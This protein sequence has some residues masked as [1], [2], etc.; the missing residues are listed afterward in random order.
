MDTIGLGLAGFGTV[1]SGVYR[2]LESN[3][4]LFAQRLGCIPLVKRIAVR[5]RTKWRPDNPPQEIVTG[6]WGELIDDDSVRV[7]IELI[8]GTTTALQLI[9]AAIEAN[10][11]VITGN[12][13]LLAEHGRELF[14]LSSA[15]GVPIY[16]EAAAAGGIPIIKTVREAL[17]GNHIESI[18]GIIN[19]TSN[20]ILSRM[21]DAGLGFSQA[22]AEAQEKGYAESDPTLDVNGWDAAHKAII[23]AS[24][25]YGFWVD[26][27]LV[28][29]E[30]IEDIQAEDVR[31]AAALGYGIK[32]LGVVKSG[33]DRD[34]EVSVR[35]TLV[36]KESVLA[37]VGGV[38]NAVAVRGDVVGDTLFYGRGAGSDATASAV[39]SDIADA[40]SALMC[41]R[42]APMFTP[43]SLY[44]RCKPVDQ[45][46]SSFYM[47]LDVEDRP[48]VLAKVATILG[49][50]KIGISS[51]IQP[52]AEEK[53]KT[54]PLVFMLHDA[55]FG[56]LREAI[57]MLDSL[58]CVRGPAHC[59]WV[60][61]L[62]DS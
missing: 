44:G 35:P 36:P 23:L 28:H 15:K 16:F 58:E 20:Y 13:A 62:S 7:V 54:V 43:H 29:V 25:A 47:R 6:D 9:R 38:F 33:G 39:I 34:I 27:T 3:R 37:S 8:G 50:R 4:D 57:S 14:E 60:D 31:F 61:T 10:K 55:P 48:G 1:G 51:V 45:I 22:L 18:R 17:I 42:P 2:H 46:V 24:L 30:G 19:G 21:V 59:L 49:E 53:E 12:K 5:D 41:S 32:L 26:H 52:E 11:P 56:I 40:A